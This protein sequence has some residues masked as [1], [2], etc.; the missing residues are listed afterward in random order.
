MAAYYLALPVLAAHALAYLAA[1]TKLRMLLPHDLHGQ[2]AEVRGGGGGGP[3]E[4]Q[5][6]RQGACTRGGCSQGSPVEKG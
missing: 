4:G 3:R 6:G 5:E 2:T 1:W